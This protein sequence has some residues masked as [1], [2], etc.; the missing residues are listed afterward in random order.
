M[1]SILTLLS[2]V[3]V[4]INLFFVGSTVAS[5][6]SHWAIYAGVAVAGFFYLLLVAYVSIHLIVALNIPCCSKLPVIT[7]SFFS[8]I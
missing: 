5:L 8:I 7:Y 6:P 4:G 3:V 2:I 1:K